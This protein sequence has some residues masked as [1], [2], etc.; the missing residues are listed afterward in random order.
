MSMPCNHYSTVNAGIDQQQASQKNIH[1]SDA[2]FH[3]PIRG[4][5]RTQLLKSEQRIK[6][7][8]SKLPWKY[9]C[10]KTASGKGGQYTKI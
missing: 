10:A 6:S 3:T 5:V 8:S 2:L 4:K 7:E 1:T 9:L